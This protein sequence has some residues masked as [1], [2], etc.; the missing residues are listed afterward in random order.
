MEVRK[1]LVLLKA[2]KKVKAELR[3]E[4]VK[5]ISLMTK[6]QLR[7]RRWL[8]HSTAGSN[9]SPWLELPGAWE[10]PV[11]EGA[12]RVSAAVGSQHRLFNGDEAT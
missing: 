1:E 6:K 10:P 9:V 5:H 7:Y 8:L 4:F 12:V 3:R 11:S 2:W